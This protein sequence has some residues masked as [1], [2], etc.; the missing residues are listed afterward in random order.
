ML[1]LLYLD[2]DGFKQINDRHG[3]HR[4]DEVLQ[5]AVTRIQGELRRTSDLVGRIGGDEFVIA[6][7]HSGPTDLAASQLAANIVARL[8]EPFDLGAGIV[9]EM[10]VSIGLASFPRHGRQRRELMHAADEAMY[11][12]KRHGK[13]A[14]VTAL[15]TA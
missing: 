13:N 2:L 4:G 9:V 14:Y 11:W 10:G 5:Q 6:L 1:S 12:V 8:C 15:S 3:H 7:A